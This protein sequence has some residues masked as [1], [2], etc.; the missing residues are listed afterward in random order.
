MTPAEWLASRTPVPP[1][2]L[3]A[4]LDE[5]L[6]GMGGTT[7]ALPEA[8][9]QAAERLIEHLLQGECTSRDSALDLL[10]ADALVTYAFEAAGET[11]ES[12]VPRATT[13]MRRIAMLGAAHRT[14]A[15][16][17]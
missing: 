11:P 5:A 16:A 8:Y 13:A 12:L 2:A 7:G 6:H 15:A 9:L 14:G 10:T 1:A 17:T 3:R 4:R